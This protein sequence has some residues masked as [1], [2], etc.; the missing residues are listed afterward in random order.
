LKFEREYEDILEELLAD[1]PDNLD[2]REASIIYNALAPAAKKIFDLFI[3]LDRVL[4]LTFASTSEDIYLEQRTAELGIRR[5]PALKAKREGIFNIAVPVGS[6]FFIDDL[7]FKTIESGV[8]ECESEG[9]VGNLP[10]DGSTLLPI[11]N[12][13][14]LETATI[15]RII[16]PGTNEQSDEELYQRYMEKISQPATSGNIYHYSQWAKEV[17]GIRAVRVFPIWNGPGTVKVVVVGSDGRAPSPEKVQEVIEHIESERPIGADVTVIAATEVPIHITADVLIVD[18][19]DIK[20]V[21]SS[22]TDELVQILRT[23][24][25]VSDYVRYSRLATLILDQK[26]VGDWQN[27]KVN[28]LTSN[29]ELG[30]EEIAVVGSVTF[31]AI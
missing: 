9:E 4:D 23:T 14:G 10:V 31:N 26:G 25:F 12:I 17:S 7:Y 1:V 19:S 15:G 30:M 18:G 21:I 28:G 24:A 3:Q 5:A 16:S 27:L 2:K 22:Y 8:L 11:D 20:D 6:R 13:P 29:I